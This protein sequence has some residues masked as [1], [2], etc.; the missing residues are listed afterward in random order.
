MNGSGIVVLLGQLCDSV[1]WGFACIGHVM[2]LH[3]DY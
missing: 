3:S 1:D 2:F